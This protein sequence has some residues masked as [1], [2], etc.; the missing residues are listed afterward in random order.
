VAYEEI[1]AVFEN[2]YRVH[3]VEEELHAHLRRKFQ[4]AGESTQDF[5]AAIHHLA[6]RTYVDSTE[7]HFSRE[8][9]RTFA[10]GV[11]RPKTTRTLWGGMGH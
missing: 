9:A 6:H 10:D 3:H 7:Q 4:H 5:I 2:R 8:A 11:T 1:T